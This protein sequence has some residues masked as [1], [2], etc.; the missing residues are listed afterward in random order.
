MSQ[1]E[2]L[3]EWLDSLELQ[4]RKISLNRNISAAIADSVLI[5]DIIYAIYPKLIQVRR[6]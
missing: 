2:D 6:F 1:I 4:K 5:V 3:L